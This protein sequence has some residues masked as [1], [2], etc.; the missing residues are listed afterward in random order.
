ME[1]LKKYV[2]GQ[3]SISINSVCV[4]G[5]EVN[6]SRIGWEDTRYVCIIPNTEKM[7]VGYC[8]TKYPK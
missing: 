2:A 4:D 1:E 8:A 6:D 3:Y 5:P 7:C